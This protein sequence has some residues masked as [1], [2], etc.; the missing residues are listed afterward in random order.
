MGGGISSLSKVAVVSPSARPDADVGLEADTL[1]SE[2]IYEEYL[3][4]ALILKGN[5]Y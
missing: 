2:A 5:E 1:D 3:Q 4:S